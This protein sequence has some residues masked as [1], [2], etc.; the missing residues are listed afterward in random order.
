MIVGKYLTIFQKLC[1]NAQRM[2]RFTFPRSI[3]KGSGQLDIRSYTLSLRD[4]GPFNP[5][6]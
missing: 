1:E 4:L 6:H 3:P 5:R 2:H